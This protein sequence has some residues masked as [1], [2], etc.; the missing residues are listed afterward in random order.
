MRSYFRQPLFL[1]LLPFFFLFHGYVENYPQIPAMDLLV[2]FIKMIV[3]F[4]I[5]WFLSRLFLKDNNGAALATFLAM[6]IFLFYGYLH[7]V[8]RINFPASFISSYKFVLGAI[9]VIFI[10]AIGLIRTRK[11]AL[12]QLR[13]YLNILLLI[14]IVV[15]IAVL[16]SK[17]LKTG[18]GKTEQMV[19]CTGSNYPDI[20]L[21]IV[22]EYAGRQQLLELFNYNNNPFLDS[23]K[24]KGFFVATNSRSNYDYTTYSVASILDMD[25]L[26]L[27]KEEI[28]TGDPI[29]GY[30][31]IFDNNL[32]SLLKSWNYDFY[33]YSFFDFKESFTNT[34]NSF[35]P[36]REKLVTSST[37]FSRLKKEAWIPLLNRIDIDWALKELKYE[38]LNYNRGVIDGTMYTVKNKSNRPKFVYTHL[39]MPHFPY[40]F[41]KEGRLYDYSEL[42]KDYLQNDST[43]LGYLQYTNKE[44]LKFVG[45]I[46]KQNRNP[47]IIV[48]MSDH[49]WRHYPSTKDP[50]YRYMN[51]LSVYLPDK[52]YEQFSDSITNVNLFRTILNK[53]FCQKFPLLKDSSTL[54]NLNFDN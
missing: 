50:R 12:G 39:E 38:N 47:P 20:Y 4:S 19:S 36:G 33:N 27:T 35:I 44:L 48:L 30:R 9:V 17:N 40:Y 51:L 24:E 42:K 25:Y 14:L 46:L 2:V 23:L 11:P 28:S 32:V 37:L 26:A 29:P 45:N 1:I 49:G 10:V 7:D 16:T 43:Y 6:L 8:L 54:V 3:G 53:S 31:T 22:D 34:A 41:D 15:D 13:L 5:V 21:I 18:A 52:K